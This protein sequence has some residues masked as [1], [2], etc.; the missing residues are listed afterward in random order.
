MLCGRRFAVATAKIL[1]RGQVTLPRQARAGAGIK[2]G[3]IVNVEVLGPGCVRLIV[4]PRLTP[5]ELRALYP[6]AG[7]IDISADREAWQSKAAADA[8]GE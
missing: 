3:D 8:L 6:I 1:A 4:L 2:P 7:P 5:R